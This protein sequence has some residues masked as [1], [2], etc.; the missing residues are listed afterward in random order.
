[1]ATD[2]FGDSSLF[3][4]FEKD[5]LPESSYIKK[6]SEEPENDKD[7]SFVFKADD[8]ESDSDSSSDFSDNDEQQQHNNERKESNVDFISED[9]RMD[10][11]STV[12]DTTDVNGTDKNS[13]LTGIAGTSGSSIKCE[14]ES[15]SKLKKDYEKCKRF[16]KLLD[17]TRHV[18]LGEGPAVQV[19]YQ[20]N[21]IA[22]K[23]RNRI[24]QYI[25]MLVQ[26]EKQQRPERLP[27]LRLKAGTLSTAD[28]NPDLSLED[29]RN[30]HLRSSHSI[31]GCSQMYD[32]FIL[33]TFGWPL[34]EHNPALTDG[35][36]IPT[37]EQVYRQV[38]PAEEEDDTKGPNQRPSRPKATCF[39]C[40]EAHMLSECPQPKDQSRIRQRRREFLEQNSSP[41]SLSK[42]LSSH[43]RYHIED[44]PRF[45]DFK[46]G[47]VSEGLR[48]AM[49]LKPQQVP[50]YIYK[51]RLLG[52]PPGW[53]QDLEE[54]T[55]G[56]SMFDKHGNEVN[57]NG[58]SLEDGEMGP[59]A[60]PPAMD[61][62]KIIEY[63]GFT[64]P[65]SAEKVDECHYLQMPPIQPHQLK[66]HI[67]EVMGRNKLKRQ[68]LDQSD[69]GGKRQRMASTS[70]DMDLD[71][72]YAVT[73]VRKMSG[74]FTSPPPLPV[75]TPPCNPPLPDGTPP[76]TPPVTQGRALNF[77][78]TGRT[79]RSA[80][81]RSSMDRQSSSGEVGGS[82]VPSE[83]LED[84]E[85]Q[86]KVLMEQ[87]AT[88]EGEDSDVVV[89]DS[90]NND[91]SNSAH[92]KETEEG[93]ISQDDS[94]TSEGTQVLTDDGEVSSSSVPNPDLVCQVLN[95]IMKPSVSV[96]RN[97]G[98]PIHKASA[99]SSLPD[100]EKFGSG[101]TD[102][103][104]FENLP[105]AT[106]TFEKLKGLLGKIR[107]KKKTKKTS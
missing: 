36:E 94:Q 44:D 20:N 85:N 88:E 17:S 83:S 56:I 86:Y 106:G 21:V 97:Y 84:L 47:Q 38:F 95:P 5:R 7:K 77:T 75:D 72:D 52:Y 27:S 74:S 103:I 19:I 48:Q 35:W 51:M 24:D 8:F 41:G 101:I 76:P 98:T 91:D 25:A 64:V 3:E 63:E 92:E 6:E 46:A 102:H 89:M 45:A 87:L 71:S 69:Q 37:Y 78:S 9:A 82:D 66:K 43:N 13:T 107:D 50:P 1:M 16:T 22:R 34:V 53:R 42:G 29:S 61:P 96:S 26:E 18:P 65:L 70:E 49:G 10:F 79:S 59:E 15:V 55:S 105:D 62:S 2:M 100:P 68:S 58:E 28:L 104:P 60:P 80:S 12:E 90:Y 93:E 23:Y 99:F 33:D 67:E 32:E 14:N 31:I 54:H 40:G 30:V 4:E 39:N 81:V 57:L 11:N 73:P